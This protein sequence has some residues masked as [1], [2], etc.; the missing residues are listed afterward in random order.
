MITEARWL[1]GSNNITDIYVDARWESLVAN[2][3]SGTHFS[4]Y[5]LINYTD[6]CKITHYT[7]F[8]EKNP[9]K[10]MKW[11]N[12][13]ISKTHRQNRQKNENSIKIHQ[14]FISPFITT[15]ICLRVWV[16]S[17]ASTEMLTRPFS[18]SRPVHT[19][20]ILI[21]RGIFQSSWQHKAHKL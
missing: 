10:T 9:Q 6:W 1:F 11:P 17:L 15:L 4:I 14:L 16:Y 20:T 7:K 3:V 8:H 13:H 18:P 12:E 2:D 19:E 5:L 21:P